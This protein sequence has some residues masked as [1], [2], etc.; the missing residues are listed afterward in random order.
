MWTVF[1]VALFCFA[2]LY[3]DGELLVTGGSDKTVR[4]QRNSR[5]ALEQV[6]GRRKRRR[7]RRR[8]SSSAREAEPMWGCKNGSGPLGSVRVEGEVGCVSL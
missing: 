5:D 8:T 7:R 4:V 3:F 6:R 2:A 1:F